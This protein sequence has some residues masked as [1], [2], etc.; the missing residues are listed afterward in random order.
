VRLEVIL[1]L[2]SFDELHR[3]VPDAFLLAEVVDRHDVRMRQPSRC[4]GFAAK[5]GDDRLGIFAARLIGANRLERDAALDQR[6]VAF[7]DDAHCAT[8]QLAP[9]LVLAQFFDVRHRSTPRSNLQEITPADR[10][11]HRHHPEQ[12]YLYL[13]SISQTDFCTSRCTIV[14]SPTPPCCDCETPNTD[15]DVAPISIFSSV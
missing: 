9:D 8:S 1:E 3:D 15:C 5:A 6:I 11:R 12:S 7:V 14:S 4:L 13:L 2:A 10:R